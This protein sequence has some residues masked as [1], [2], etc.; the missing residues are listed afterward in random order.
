MA[1][2]TAQLL[3]ACNVKADIDSQARKRLQAAGHAVKT[4]TERLVEAAR[5]AVIQDERNIIIAD[6]MVHGIAQVL[7]LYRE[8]ERMFR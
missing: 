3:I 5:H 6:R 4:S 7:T 8:H 2:S 1:S